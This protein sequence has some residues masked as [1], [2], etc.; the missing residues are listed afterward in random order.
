MFFSH[1]ASLGIL[2]PHSW[3]AR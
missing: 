2:R 1:G 3:N